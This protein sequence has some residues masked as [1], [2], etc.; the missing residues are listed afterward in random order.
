MSF[1]SVFDV[2]DTDCPQAQL[3]VS[4]STCNQVDL[5]YVHAK[6]IRQNDEH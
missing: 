5:F 6:W 1:E 2:T 3:A 4:V